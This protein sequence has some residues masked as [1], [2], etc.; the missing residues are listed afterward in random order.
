MKREK[1]EVVLNVVNMAG[2]SRFE[3]FRTADLLGF[4]L[5]HNHVWALE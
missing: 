4:S 1:S 2:G 5:H 3:Y